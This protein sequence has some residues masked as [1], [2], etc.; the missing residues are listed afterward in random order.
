MLARAAARRTTARLG[1]CDFASLQD[2][3]APLRWLSPKTQIRAL[4]R[5]PHHTSG[6]G[7]RLTSSSSLLPSAAETHTIQKTAIKAQS[8]R[9]LLQRDVERGSSDDVPAEEAQLLPHRVV[10][11]VRSVR[12]HRN[13]TFLGLA[14]GSLPGHATLQAVVRHQAANPEPQGSS[15]DLVRQLTPGAAVEVV[16]PL[17]SSKGRGQDVEMEVQQLSVTGTCD[18]ATYPVHLAAPAAPAPPAA[19][20]IAASGSDL[21]RYAH[22]RPRE[23]RHAAILRTRD[24]MERGIDSFFSRRDF[25]RVA[26]PI[27]T[28]SD[29]E[30][31]GEVF[32]VLSEAEHAESGVVKES[33]A[34]QDSAAGTRGSTSLGGAAAGRRQ[35]FWGGSQAYLTVSAQLHLEAIVLGLGRVYTVGPSFRAEGSATNR[36]LAEFWM[37]EGEQ[38]TSVDSDAALDEV[39]DTVEGV[40][41]QAIASALANEQLARSLWSHDENGL[42]A[43]R[44]SSHSQGRWPRITY[45]EAIGMLQEAANEQDAPDSHA[46]PS[47][48]LLAPPAWGESLASEH[49]RWLA[50]NGPIFVTHYPAATKPFYMR[51][52]D[53]PDGASGATG[54]KRDTVACFDLLVPHVGELVGGSLR[55][56]RSDV[57]QKRMVES[58]QMVAQCKGDESSD[59]TLPPSA[60]ALGSASCEQLTWYAED[61][62]R[63]GCNPHGGF[64]LGIERLLAWVTGTESVRDVVTF[65]R[66]KGRLRY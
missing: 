16:G 38:L 12:H 54:Y 42:A 64:G 60:T 51:L 28:A 29:C 3:A 27:I 52:D 6:L 56:T 17:R 24:A 45:S 25:I 2:P 9:A 35:G 30:G 44:H 43:V 49:E 53:V 36:H 5:S 21:R 22:L 31:G 8:I 13:V 62:R 15:Q 59:G 66:V 14:D 41:R 63:Y 20:T 32:R 19:A 58:Q 4:A 55:E 10:A 37:C 65:P 57:L 48:A 39:T 1:T 46:A 40:V 11:Y 26:A 18:A 47:K 7:R 61:L 23:A 50:R 34:S 33:T